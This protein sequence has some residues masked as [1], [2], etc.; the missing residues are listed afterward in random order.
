MT[1]NRVSFVASC[2][3][4][5]AE[6]TFAIPKSSTLTTSP[7]DEPVTIITFSGLMSRCTTPAACAAPSASSTCRAIPRARVGESG[8]SLTM[9]RRLRP[10]T[11][12]RTRKNDPSGSRPK[13]LAA[14]TD[15]CWIFPAAIASRS[16]RA[17]SSFDAIARGSRTFSA[18]RFRI[19]TC[20]ARN[21]APIAP[22]PSRRMTR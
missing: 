7:P 15:G 21:T 16:N 4:R 11:N 13:S 14:H 2:C 9:L 17:T 22:A 19:I 5:A 20:S 3:P 10:S 1:P 12:S 6:S 8:P 18:N